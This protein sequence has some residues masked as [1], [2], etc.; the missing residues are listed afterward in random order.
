MKF[1]KPLTLALSILAGMVANYAIAGDD[2]AHQLHKEVHQIKVEVDGGQD[3]HLFIDANG[4]KMEKVIPMDIFHDQDK[5]AAALS[6]LPEQEREKLLST[7]SKLSSDLHLVKHRHVEGEDSSFFTENGEN[8]V[9]I[10]V[11]SEE[12]GDDVTKVVKKFIH[13]G[14]EKVV[15][16]KH[17]GSSTQALLHMIKSGKFSKEELIQLQQAL[18]EKH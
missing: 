13:H 3:A 17:S 1:T 6:D 10:D 15:K 16:V 8:I 7:L 18:D 11:D 2:K 5:L 4:K 9:V 14:G 12:L